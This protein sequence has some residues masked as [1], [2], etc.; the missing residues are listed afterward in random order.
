MRLSGRDRETWHTLG[1]AE[2]LRPILARERKRMERG[3]FPA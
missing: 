2:W 1:G 3:K